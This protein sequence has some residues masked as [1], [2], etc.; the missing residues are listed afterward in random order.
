VADLRELIP[1]PDEQRSLAE[2]RS[3]F[4]LDALDN[5]RSQYVGHHPIGWAMIGDPSR[6]R[7]KYTAEEWS[8]EMLHRLDDPVTQDFG[9]TEARYTWSSR[10]EKEAQAALAHDS[11]TWDDSVAGVAD[12]DAPPCA[13]VT[14]MTD[15]DLCE[16]VDR[17][18]RESE[19]G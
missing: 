15:D 6:A 16:Y 4:R 2:L 9:L 1:H 17:S 18:I 7:D 3:E 10:L 11:V 13:D 14:T 8:F 12:A 5:L 19:R